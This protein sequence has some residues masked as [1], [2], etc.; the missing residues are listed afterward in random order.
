[1]SLR[2]RLTEWRSKR[3]L[4]FVELRHARPL[5]CQPLRNQ[6][7][8]I[9]GWC[10]KAKQQSWDTVKRA[11]Y[12]GLCAPVQ[13]RPLG[14]MAHRTCGN[15]GETQPCVRGEARAAGHALRRVRQ[16]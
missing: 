9:F 16:P 5:R 14:R 15:A 6:N 13:V 1:M 8:S 3:Y 7:L 11:L 10:R 12:A 2:C 4:D